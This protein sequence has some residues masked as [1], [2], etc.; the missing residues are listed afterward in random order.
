MIIALHG[1][2]ASVVSVAVALDVESG[3]S[4]VMVR[5]DYRPQHKEGVVLTQQIDKAYSGSSAPAVKRWVEHTVK[6]MEQI[7]E[8]SDKEGEDDDGMGWS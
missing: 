2:S 8:E 6:F 5:I 1:G 7:L 3:G 4:E